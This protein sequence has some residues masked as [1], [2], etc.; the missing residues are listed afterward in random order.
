M[1]LLTRAL[2]RGRRV[3]GRRGV[4][5]HRARRCSS[6]SSSCEVAPGSVVDAALRSDGSQHD[7]DDRMTRRIHWDDRKRLQGSWDDVKKG[8]RVRVEWKDTPHHGIG[9]FAARDVSAGT[10]LRA[11]EWGRNLMRFRNVTD[12]EDF[13]R[14]HRVVPASP[15]YRARLRYVADYLWGFYP[16]ADEAGYPSAV[17]DENDRF[18]GM[19]IPGNGLNHSPQPN[20]VYRTSSKGIVHGIDLVALT[21]ITRGEE[22]YDDYRRHGT[23]PAWLREFGRRHRVNLNFADCNDFVDAE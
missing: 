19:W 22:L 17:E 20:T 18:Y 1:T 4:V 23:A 10:L 14:A 21:N 13:L 7:D 3:G 15:V 12:V 8:W 9:L 6:S 5:H 16:Q 11:G 2:T